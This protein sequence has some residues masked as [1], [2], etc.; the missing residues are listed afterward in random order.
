[1]S[2]PGAAYKHPVLVNSVPETIFIA[3]SLTVLITLPYDIFSV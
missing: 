2:A 1:M 3:W